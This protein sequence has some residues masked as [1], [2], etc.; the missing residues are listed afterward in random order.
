LAFWRA[1]ARSRLGR[2]GAGVLIVFGIAQFF[3][4]RFRVDCRGIDA[5]CD[6]LGSWHAKAHGMES[7]VTIL[8]FLFAPF[9]LAWAFHHLRRWR[10]MPLDDRAAASARES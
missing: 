1:L 9:V 5:G 3:D 2:F 6:P 7:G 8:C 10:P 4:G